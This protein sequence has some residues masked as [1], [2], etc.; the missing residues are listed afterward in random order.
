MIYKRGA[1]Y[2]YKFVWQGRLIREA[3]KQGRTMVA[4]GMEAAH[5]TRLAKGE[6]GIR[7]RK[8]ALLLGEF[9]RDRFAPWAESVSSLKTWRDF[10]R[11]GLLA[12][13]NY[14]A[15]ASLPLDAITTE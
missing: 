1:R 6:V 8:P 5:R 10:Y 7:E 11:V 3:T 15:L 4:R 12:I 13:Q 2:W 14:T 9:C